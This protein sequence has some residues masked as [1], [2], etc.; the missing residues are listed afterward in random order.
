MFLNFSAHENP[1]ERERFSR[2]FAVIATALVF[3]G[4]LALFYPEQ[5]LLNLVRQ[6]E[7]K[8]PAARVYLQAL[9]R[10]RPQDHD[11]R[12]RLAVHYMDME[13]YRQALRVLDAA[14]GEVSVA[15]RERYAE[16][17]VASLERL[18]VLEQADAWR[19]RLLAL[20]RPI[21]TTEPTGPDAYR[22]RAQS[23]FDQM[24]TAA[25]LEQRRTLFFRAIRI[26]QEGNLLMEAL[27]AAD[28]HI[29]RLA[30][31]RET[32]IFLTRLALSANRPDL[33]QVYIRRALGLPTQGGNP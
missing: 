29:G 15:E 19:Q 32:L 18:F 30:G 12:L 31:D 16:L 25:S 11:L 14:V 23:A 22:R 26:L 24:N 21:E 7:I 9:L 13:Q 28:A 2:P 27:T 3:M 17:L 6:D 20:G 10:K 33:A 8:G 1:P 5:E 4:V